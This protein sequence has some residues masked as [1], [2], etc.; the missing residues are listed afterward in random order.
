MVKLTVELSR[1]MKITLDIVGKQ[2]S[3]TWYKK[4]AGCACTK[5]KGIAEQMMDDD[6]GN[7]EIIEVMDSGIDLHDLWNEVYVCS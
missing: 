4:S 6:F 2:Y 3:E 1:E 5:G 7:E